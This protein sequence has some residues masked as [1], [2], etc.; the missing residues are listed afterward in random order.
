MVIKIGFKH[1]RLQIIHSV[2]PVA[3]TTVGF[4]LMVASREG[5]GRDKAKSAKLLSTLAVIVAIVNKSRPAT[6]EANN[7]T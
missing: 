3:S 6:L 1:V 2:S 4:C 5:V 7:T